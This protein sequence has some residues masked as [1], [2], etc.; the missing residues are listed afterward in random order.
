[1]ELLLAPLATFGAVALLVLI[2]VP[3]QRVDAQ[4]RVATFAG[5]DPAATTGAQRASLRLMLNS[6]LDSIGKQASKVA[7]GQ[8]LT[9]M[10]ELLDQ[11]GNPISLESLLALRVAGGLFFPGVY[12]LLLGQSEHTGIQLLLA[13]AVCYLGSYLPKFWVDRKAENR[14]QAIE[15]SLPNALDLIV[16]SMEAGLA[17]D[18]AVAKVV[19]RTSGP[20]AQEFGRTLREMQLGKSRRDALRD[21]ASRCGIKDVTT[22]V[23]GIIQADQMGVSMAE[24]MR[25]QADESR[26]VRRQRAEE[27]AHQASVKMVFP[28]ILFI[29]PS[30]LIVAVGPAALTIYKTLIAGDVFK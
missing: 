24:L 28:L 12:F 20:L 6:I 13:L 3:G 15:R 10:R 23:N 1:M 21:L 29:L 14:R 11:A 27:K 16:V 2:F 4:R 5:M 8:S 18:A 7:L 9:G 19:E 30:L 17:L 26:V 22:L 25:T